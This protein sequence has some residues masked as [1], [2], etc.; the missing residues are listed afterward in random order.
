MLDIR[1]VGSYFGLY[2]ENGLIAVLSKKSCEVISKLKEVRMQHCQAIVTS[3]QWMAAVQEWT[4]RRALPVI[5]FELVIY[6]SK[7]DADG[8]GETLSEFEITLQPPIIDLNGTE[9]YNP[10]YL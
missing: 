2:F 4:D 10:H 8:V 9:Y 1:D 7:F 6:G 3:E 5:E